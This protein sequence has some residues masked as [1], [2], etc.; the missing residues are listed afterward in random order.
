MRRSE[1]KA[2]SIPRANLSITNIVRGK[3]SSSRSGR[4]IQS[5][6]GLSTR[7]RRAAHCRDTSGRIRRG[8]KDTTW[9]RQDF[10]EKGGENMEPH[11]RGGGEMGKA[12]IK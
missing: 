6:K 3:G 10:K 4:G 7:R 12:M 1:C 5:K 8:K 9:G 2:G 11:L